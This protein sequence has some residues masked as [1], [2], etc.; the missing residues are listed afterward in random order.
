MYRVLELKLGW[1]ILIIITLNIL[2]AIL[3]FSIQ[4]MGYISIYVLIAEFV[5]GT[6]T[7]VVNIAYKNNIVNRISIGMALGSIASFLIGI[8]AILCLFSGHVC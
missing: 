5:I 2:V 8:I 1:Y 6:I 4:T 7:A 3:D